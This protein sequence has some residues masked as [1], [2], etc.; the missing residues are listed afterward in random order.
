MDTAKVTCSNRVWWQGFRSSDAWI[1]WR[2]EATASTPLWR[3]TGA[4]RT[5]C[6]CQQFLEFSE[7]KQSCHHWW[8]AWGCVQI[9]LDMSKQQGARVIW[10]TLEEKLKTCHPNITPPLRHSGIP[11]QTVTTPTSFCLCL[12]LRRRKIAGATGVSTRDYKL[13]RLWDVHWCYPSSWRLLKDDGMWGSWVAQQFS[14]FF[15][16]F[17][18]NEK[19]SIWGLMHREQQLHEHLQLK[20]CSPTQALLILA[21]EIS[22]QV[23]TTMLVIGL[24][25]KCAGQ[26]NGTRIIKAVSS[27]W[28]EDLRCQL[29][30]EYS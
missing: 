13:T 2:Q 26:K 24:L 6:F 21:N 3:V 1:Q 11:L 5:R 17:I 15:C 4:L 10:N 27:G 7:L 28:L 8:S 9:R 14:S 18:R 20:L 23:G 16:Q 29:N 22:A 12:Y 19:Q 25:T 30:N